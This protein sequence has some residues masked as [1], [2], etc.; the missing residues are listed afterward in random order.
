MVIQI[1]IYYG[2]SESTVMVSLLLEKGRAMVI[3]RLN[4]KD[5]KVYKDLMD[6]CFGTSNDLEHYQ[7]YQENHAYKIF[8]VKAG[9]TIIGSVTLYPIDLFTFDFQPCLMVFNVAVKTA[10]REKQIAKSLLAHSIEYA[11]KEGYRSIT[12]TCLDDAYPAHRL[13]ES[14]GFKK[15]K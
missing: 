3:E 2:A 9:D 7:K 11:K 10:Y 1:V 8:V 15:G 14:I 12:L 13:Y 4:P 6:E 5:L